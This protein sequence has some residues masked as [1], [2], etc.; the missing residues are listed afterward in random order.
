[1]PNGGISDCYGNS[2]T[3][4]REDQD[5][6]GDDDMLWRNNLILPELCY[7]VG[8]PKLAK[9]CHVHTRG[10]NVSEPQLGNTGVVAS[11]CIHKIIPEQKKHFRRQENGSETDEVEERRLSN[12]DEPILSVYV[13]K[14]PR[15]GG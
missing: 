5:D 12:S 13:H 6:K 4:H 15:Q 3:D 2:H 10:A 1:M 8:P 9:N 14:Y 11:R 7:F